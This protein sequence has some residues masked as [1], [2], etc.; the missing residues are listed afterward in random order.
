MATKEINIYSCNCFFNICL[1][2]YSK[3]DDFKQLSHRIRN[4]CDKKYEKQKRNASCPCSNCTPI[5]K[6]KN[7][8]VLKEV[9]YEFDFVNKYVVC[10]NY[11]S[12]ILKDIFICE[13]KEKKMNCHCL[14][15]R[16]FTRCV[17]RFPCCFNYYRS[18]L[19]T[20]E[21][22]CVNCKTFLASLSDFKLNKVSLIE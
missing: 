3:N 8:W 10:K 17:G 22:F 12:Y 2:S 15:R 16:T 9:N 1:L 6:L 5:Y 14:E 13:Y 18:G 11:L 20:S 21:Y 7:N 4:Y 19:L